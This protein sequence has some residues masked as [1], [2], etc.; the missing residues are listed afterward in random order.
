MTNTQ[1]YISPTGRMISLGE[2]RDNPKRNFGDEGYQFVERGGTSFAAKAPGTFGCSTSPE[3]LELRLSLNDG[4]RM[5]LRAHGRGSDSH[6][7]DYLTFEGEQYFPYNGSNV[8]EI[9]QPREI[10]IAYQSDFGT[11][12]VITRDQQ[13]DPPDGSMLRLY[14]GNE[15]V[16]SIFTLH[17]VDFNMLTRSG[18]NGYLEFTSNGTVSVF[19]GRSRKSHMDGAPVQLVDWHKLS[20]IDEHEHGDFIKLRRNA[21]DHATAC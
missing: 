3:G 11:L 21:A 5:I 12:Y 19:D 10:L 6:S 2:R 14:S 20:I 1:T 8:P 16:G 18:D 9:I 15:L 17:G 7:Y 13:N 4:R